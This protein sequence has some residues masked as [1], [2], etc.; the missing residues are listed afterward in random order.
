M[1]GG[2][3]L[4]WLNPIG[5]TALPWSRTI[6]PS[7]R[8]PRP[9]GLP[10]VSPSPQGPRPRGRGDASARSP[11]PQLPAHP[12]AWQRLEGGS[13]SCPGVGA[14]NPL[15]FQARASGQGLMWTKQ[16]HVGHRSPQLAWG[17]DTPPNTRVL[18]SGT[19][20]PR[21]PLCQSLGPIQTLKTWP[22]PG[23]RV[24]GAA[25]AWGV[26]PPGSSSHDRGVTAR[27]SCEMITS[28]CNPPSA[29]HP[30]KGWQDRAP[31]QHCSAEQGTGVRGWQR[32]DVPSRLAPAG[33]AR[34]G[35][36]DEPT[37]PP[38]SRRGRALLRKRHLQLPSR[39][40]QLP[41]PGGGQAARSPEIEVG[42]RRFLLSIPP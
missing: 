1:E 42:Q 30:G 36:Q 26:G 22:S 18:P 23:Q 15:N 9:P 21:P 34:W 3:S 4:A 41:S 31:P 35:S 16:L 29:Q 12:S 5:C 25:P 37:R 13:R 28:L 32:A 38:G 33:T 6:T 19:L 11:C 14:P 24:R 10:A 39:A 2:G 17:G 20:L 8:P 40:G 7:R 27:Q